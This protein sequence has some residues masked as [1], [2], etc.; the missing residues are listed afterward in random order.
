MIGRMLT[1]PTSDFQLFETI[2]W[3]PG[4]GYW[5][6]EKHLERLARGAQFFKFSCDL[7]TVRKRLCQEELTF[8]GGCYRVRLVLAK[9]GGVS[10]TAVSCDAPVNT[11][12]PLNP[13][14]V[15]ASGCAIVDFSTHIVDA[16]SPWLFYKTTMRKL[17]DVAYKHA[18]E[19]GLFDYV[20]CNSAGEVTE[21]CITNIVIYNDGKYITPPVAS[22]LLAG[23]MR[24]HLLASSAVPIVEKVLTK[25]EVRSAKALFLCNSVRGLVRVRMK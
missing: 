5:L 13:K 11:E 19:T 12:L 9:D 17:Y 24:E 16:G 6:L 14:Q 7:T 8:K 1:H 18:Q 15:D 10:I 23:T 22:G 3:R 4:T 20:F 25:E 2:L 21:G